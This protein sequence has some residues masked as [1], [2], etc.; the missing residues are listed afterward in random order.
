MFTMKDSLKLVMLVILSLFSVNLQAQNAVSDDQRLTDEPRDRPVTVDIGGKYYCYT[1]IFDGESYISLT[2]WACGTRSAPIARYDVF[3]RIALEVN[4]KWLCITAP[5]GVT[6][7]VSRKVTNWGYVV[8]RPCAINE[9]N[10]RWIIKDNAFY[11]YDGKYR[12][13]DYKTYAVISDGNS[14]SSHTLDFRMN[15]WVNTVAWPANINIK[16]NLVWL[17]NRGPSAQNYYIGPY[18]S[19]PNKPLQLYYNAQDGR[20]FYYAPKDGSETCM[21]TTQLRNQSWNWVKWVDC[22]DYSDFDYTRW[23]LFAFT[24]GKGALRDKNGNVLRTARYGPSWGVAYTV[25]PYY[26]NSDTNYSPTSEFSMSDDVDR[27]I[28]YANGNMGDTLEYCPAPGYP[29]HVRTK[30]QLPPSF[31]ISDAWINRFYAIATSAVSGTSPGVGLCG[32]CMLHTSEIVAELMRYPY[33]NPPTSTTGQF[34][35]IGPRMNPFDSFTQRFPDLAQ[36]IEGVQ[37]FVEYP[38]YVDENRWTRRRRLIYAMYY[39]FFPQYNLSPTSVAMDVA[40]LRQLFDTIM[41]SPPGSIWIIS[42]V[43]MSGESVIGHSQPAL[44]LD[45]GIT[46]IPTNAPRW[47]IQYYRSQL[48][49]SNTPEEFIQTLYGG[50]RRTQILSAFGIRVD[51]QYHNSYNRF[52]STNN[53]TGGGVDGSRGSGRYPTIDRI[54]QCLSG[55]CAIQ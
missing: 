24:N 50:G 39:A 51:G 55:R 25:A 16:T 52:I 3:Q 34:F 27:W 47:N 42:M 41:D 1:P 9:P 8:L 5:D 2:S 17:F 22:G 13:Q 30:R 32:V 43:Y 33:G 18:R 49:P 6:G 19:Y 37:N 45:N 10:Q 35:N 44:R 15:Q 38:L 23:E 46:M 20:I 40:G 53:C 36:R 26:L 29:A 14:Y 48:T 4:S 21:A 7:Y 28:R 12:I 31:Q 11:T 54:N